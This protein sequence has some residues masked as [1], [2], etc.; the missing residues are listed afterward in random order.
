MKDADAIYKCNKRL[1]N[2]IHTLYHYTIADKHEMYRYT[3]EDLAIYKQL[4]SKFPLF[5]SD[6]GV[7][8]KYLLELFDFHHIGTNHMLEEL[9]S[10]EGKV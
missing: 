2:Q 8:Y 3:A 4:N 1:Y 5:T 10:I 9:L 7:T 6:S